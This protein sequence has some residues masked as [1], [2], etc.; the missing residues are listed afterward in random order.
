MNV[1]PTIKQ[2]DNALV[3]SPLLA[4][5]GIESLSTSCC[6]CKPYG[7][8]RSIQ[9]MPHAEGRSL[10]AYA[11]VTCIVAVSICGFVLQFSRA[12]RKKRF[13]VTSISE[14][15]CL[16]L[17]NTVNFLYKQYSRKPKFDCLYEMLLIH[18]GG[19]N[20]GKK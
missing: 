1:S 12:S 6:L 5:C 8:R 18:R 17:L 11:A 14:M 7:Q 20:I 2:C 3:A 4:G 10:H 9:P 15:N 19:F 16:I 13:S